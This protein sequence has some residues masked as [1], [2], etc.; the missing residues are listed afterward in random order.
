M[1]QILKHLKRETDNDIRRVGYFNTS[2][3]SMDR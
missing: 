1:K 3:I 2:L